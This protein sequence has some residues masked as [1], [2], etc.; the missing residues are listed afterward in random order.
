MKFIFASAIGLL[1]LITSSY[2]VVIK[3]LKVI[4]N[5]RITKETI[6]T[7]GDIELN[8]DYNKKE[9]NQIIKNLYNTNFFK[10][11]TLSTEGNTLI[12]KVVENKIIQSVKIEGVESNRIKEN[13]L[14][15]LFSKDKSPFLIEKVK[16]DEDRM[17]TSL[18][19]IGYYLSEVKSKI[20]ENNND[21][22]DLIFEVNLGEKSKITKIDFVGDKKIKDRILR[23]IIISEEAKF[24]KIISNNKYVNKDIIERDKRLL[25]N[26]YLNKGYYDVDVQS[27]TVKF[28]DNQSFKLTYKIEAGEIYSVNNTK[29]VLPIDYDETNFKDVKDQ[30]NKLINKPFS[31]NKISKVVDEID[32][33]S[34]SREYDFINANY[35]ETKIGGNKL[36]IIF[37]VTE[38]EKFYVERINIFGNNI[39][40]EAVIRNQL[41]IDEG[42]AFNEL[43]SAKSIN[44]LKSSNLFK[45]VNSTVSEGEEIN[46]KVIDITVEEKPTGEIMVGA[47]AGSEGG[48]LGFAVTENNFLGKGIKLSSNL[49]LTEDSI[50]GKFSVTNPNFNYSDKSLSTSVESTNT[51][52]LSES[53]YKS[54]K[55]GFTVG[56]GFEQF[57]NVYF[58]PRISNFYE[59]L[60]TKSTASKN[61][62]K[63]SGTY[64]TSKFSY[65]LDYDMRNQR[66]QTSDG[67]RSRFNQSIP[68][69]SEEYSLS[70][71]YDYKTWYKL[72]NNMVTSFNFYGRTVNSLTGDDVRIT[73]RFWLPRKKLKG[74]KTRNVGP[75]DG[76]DYVGGNYAAALNFDTTLPMI[77]STVENVDVRYFVDTAN[78]WGV[79][80]SSSVDQSNTIRASTGFVIDW[81]TPIGP[82]NFSLAQDLSKADDDRTETFQ[83][84]LGTT[85]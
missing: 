29:L 33:I 40:H 38:S 20:V 70:N 80:Y 51:D 64:L 60:T 28:L 23:G 24:W 63:Q 43:L 27:A 11:L 3:D 32:N 6:I 35:T 21:T 72:P 67:F 46:T 81:F 75:R 10:N 5:N 4:D 30:L 61:L 8:K 9:L 66:F 48:T 1:L 41:E 55:T 85:F 7:Y 26:F 59:D 79:D 37:E 15:N 77:F 50:K 14:K 73:N 13:I 39:T 84:S 17:K 22:V 12:L 56:T 45:T 47:G 74:F 54:T 82:L 44:N 68:L 49:D 19:S 34:L 78:L 36:D 25:R 52:K 57:Q 76:T 69:I 2:A 16:I 53:G 65:G 62:R 71:I 83:F 58:T 31:I 18:S 42:D